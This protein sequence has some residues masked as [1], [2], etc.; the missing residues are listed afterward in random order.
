MDMALKI[1]VR[2]YVEDNHI[3]WK[4]PWGTEKMHEAFCALYDTCRLEEFEE[5]L[6][7]LGYTLSLEHVSGYQLKKP[8]LPPRVISSETLRSNLGLRENPNR[9]M[10][11]H[12]FESR[13]GLPTVRP[14]SC[15]PMP[16]VKPMKFNEDKKTLHEF[17][18]RLPSTYR[19]VEEAM[20]SASNKC[21]PEI[22]KKFDQDKPDWSLLPLNLLT[23]IVKVLSFGAKKYN[24][25]NWRKVP[26]AKNRY[27]A[28]L[29]RHFSAWQADEKDDPETGL[30]HLYHMG[31]CLLFLIWFDENPQAGV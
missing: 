1:N 23:G 19:S 30:S 21:M 24:R 2:K 27:S 16:T 26:D 10:A 22:G 20:E 3:Q 18:S 6:R 5:A 15:P 13:L 8:T 25:E 7:S 9:E 4:F 29:M 11:I 28:A 31:C 14:E 12:D 17:E